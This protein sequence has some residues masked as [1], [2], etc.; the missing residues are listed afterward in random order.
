MGQTETKTFP[1]IIYDDPMSCIDVVM[2]Q[3][4]RK[5]PIPFEKLVK[6]NGGLSGAEVYTYMDKFVIKIYQD[7]FSGA[8][9]N[10]YSRGWLDALHSC[11]LSGLKHFPLSYGVFCHQGKLV[12]ITEF[13][14]GETLGKA[15]LDKMKPKD[16]VRIADELVQALQ[17]AT[18]RLGFFI[19]FDFHPGNIILSQNVKIIDFDLSGSELVGFT[20]INEKALESTRSTPKF[21]TLD[22]VSKYKKKSEIKMRYYSNPDIINLNMILMVLLDRRV[23]GCDDI[24]SCWNAIHEESRKRKADDVHPA[25]RQ[26][27]RSLTESQKKYLDEFDKAC[28]E[29]AGS[30]T[31]ISK[32]SISLH[33]TLQKSITLTNGNSWLGLPTDFTI[34]ISEICGS[35][36]INLSTTGYFRLKKGIF[37]NNPCSIRIVQKEFSVPFWYSQHIRVRNFPTSMSIQIWLYSSPFPLPETHIEKGGS[38]EQDVYN[39]L[40]DENVQLRSF[41]I[42]LRSQDDSVSTNFVKGVS[43]KR[44]IEGLHAAYALLKS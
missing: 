33:L 25:K 21:Q 37:E 42:K 19:H 35:Q 26:K 12:S 2:H 1:P 9:I 32:L 31:P 38:C 4:T 8:W 11:A 20:N 13:I 24:I 14:H 43:K 7:A 39:T 44:L 18:Q 22:F 10:L 34:T 17:E 36:T 5:M 28:L 30:L 40:T 16:K 41:T 6:I 27:L 23:Q 15:D 3:C 29:E